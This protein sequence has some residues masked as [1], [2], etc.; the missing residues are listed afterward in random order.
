M[1]TPTS[2]DPPL[3][4]LVVDHSATIRQIILSMANEL[5]YA[6]IEANSYEHA[7]LQLHADDMIDLIVLDDLTE[8]ASEKS[9]ISLI[10]ENEADF[11]IILTTENPYQH[12]H[13]D[14]VVLG[15]PFKLDAFGRAI[16]VALG[17]RSATA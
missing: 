17:W 10:R 3:T 6:T 12:Q 7:L 15:K 13:C 11:P 4:L 8:R 1:T 16:T 5:G 14:A 2:F 9:F